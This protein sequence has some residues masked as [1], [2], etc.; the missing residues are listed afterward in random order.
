MKKYYIDENISI[1]PNLLI[2]DL[3]IWINENNQLIT[4]GTLGIENASWKYTFKHDD[5]LNFDSY[6]DYIK[7]QEKYFNNKIF[8]DTKGDKFQIKL[9]G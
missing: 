2:D 1:Y 7:D 8:T 5:L 6:N 9:K 3:V 4:T